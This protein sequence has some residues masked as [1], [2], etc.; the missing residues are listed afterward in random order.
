[1]HAPMEFQMS[2]RKKMELHCKPRKLNMLFFF[3]KVGHC[4]LVLWEVTCSDKVLAPMQFKRFVAH[5][6]QGMGLISNIE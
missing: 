4:E 1:M 6:K 5:K 2:G 3:A